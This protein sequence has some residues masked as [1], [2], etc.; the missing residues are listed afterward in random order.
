LISARQASWN[1]LNASRDSE[2]R[3]G[4]VPASDCLFRS[5]VGGILFASI[6]DATGAQAR[7]PKTIHAFRWSQKNHNVLG[8]LWFSICFPKTS[9]LHVY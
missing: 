2:I 5:R 1:A 9:Y 8:F 6:L 4:G 3:S 7:Q